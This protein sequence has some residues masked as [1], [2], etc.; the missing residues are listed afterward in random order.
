M[1]AVSG[2]LGPVVGGAFAERVTWRWC[3]WV[4]CTSQS[5]CNQNMA[6][7][8]EVPLDAISLVVLGLL[9]N[10][11]TP[12]TPLRKGLKA[13]DWIGSLSILGAT[14]LLLLGLQFGGVTA[15]WNSAKVVCMIIFGILLFGVFCITQWKVSEFPLIPLRI[16][17]NRSNSAV[18]VVCLFHGMAFISTLY[19]LPVYYQSVLGA[20]PLSSGIW[21]LPLAISSTL[22]MFVV[23]TYVKKKGKYLR[24]IRV[25][26]ACQTLAFGLFINFQPY[27]SWPRLIVYQTIN[28]LAIGVNFQT[29]MVALQ[30]GLAPGDL[31]T[32]TAT[33]GFIRMMGYA[34]GVVV[35]QVV[36]QT[37]VHGQSSTLSAAG[38]PVELV[39]AIAHGDVVSLAADVKHL[40]AVQQKI[41]RKA[42][43]L[44]LN[45]M[46]ILFTA[47]SFIAFLTSFAI[48]GKELSKEHQKS[49]LGLR[50]HSET[51]LE[52]AERIEVK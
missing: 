38:I 7:A 24:I 10:V 40:T 21:L 11:E 31:A 12:K 46:W 49:R 17:A 15:P 36:F 25:G 9:F 14:L 16:L 26:L 39:S 29:L 27:M 8:H 13:I 28:G 6:N 33:F 48:A 44:G 2:A 19:F 37:Q 5:I 32:G 34:I 22:F 47:I 41:L 42:L 51:R 52:D 18:L 50:P 23:G 3:F 35:G 43:T 4:N 30:N 20:G 45:R 1:W